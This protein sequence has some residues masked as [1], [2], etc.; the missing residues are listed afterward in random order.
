MT[1]TCSTELKCSSPFHK[2]MS[3]YYCC[4]YS[5]LCMTGEIWMSCI[6]WH[7]YIRVNHCQ[8]NVMISIF[9]QYSLCN[10]FRYGIFYQCINVCFEDFWHK[11]KTAIKRWSKNYPLSQIFFCHCHIPESC[12]ILRSVNRVVW[13]ECQFMG[14]HFL[15][16][17]NYVFTD[18]S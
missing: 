18:F 1:S 14:L 4:L 11:K 6:Y 17:G 8:S 7:Q 12:R 5:T 15:E 9:T 2:I 13:P 16:G 3:K 10:S